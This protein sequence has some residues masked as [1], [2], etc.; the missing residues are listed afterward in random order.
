V[1]SGDE[2]RLAMR[3]HAA[4]VCVVTAVVDR[5][6]FGAT[7]GSLVSLSLDPALVGVSVGLSSSFHEP[8]REAGRYGVSLLA[9]DQARLA[10]HFGRSGVPPIALWD[11]IEL[12]ASEPEPLLDGALGWLS[13]VTREEHRVGDHTLF[14]G[15]V[16]SLEVG[17][18][19]DA[20][21]YVRH[22]YERV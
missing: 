21:V 1:V 12:H 22:G 16:E 9:G 17:R 20:L 15:E 13:C 19:D 11:G 2:L 8:L 4:G 5:E 3:R 6:R 14:V 18:E 10:Q 7:I